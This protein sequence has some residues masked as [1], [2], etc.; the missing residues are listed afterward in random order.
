MSTEN[1]LEQLGFKKLGKFILKDDLDVELLSATNENGVYVFSSEKNVKYIGETE[2]GFISRIGSYLK[3]G[4]RQMTN[5]RLK[6]EIKKQLSE[7]RIVEILFLGETSIKQL[8]RIKI[9]DLEI[10]LT[11]R[12][13]E[14]I[15]IDYFKPEW[16][17]R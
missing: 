5:I 3:P 9:K 17:L 1:F 16:N 13:L 2:R 14:R 7:G 4:P 12:L 15:L 6:E 8:D 11:R 10:S